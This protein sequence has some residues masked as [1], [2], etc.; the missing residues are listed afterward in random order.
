S[1]TINIIDSLDY[2]DS[3]KKI[4]QTLLSL[5]KQRNIFDSKELLGV[6]TENYDRLLYL[7]ARNTSNR[8]KFKNLKGLGGKSSIFT[9]KK[10][11][12]P[13]YPLFKSMAR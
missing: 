5:N 1:C 9:L 13:L 8:Y 7:Y 4:Y 12:A 10:Y 2:L 6:L 11:L 3:I